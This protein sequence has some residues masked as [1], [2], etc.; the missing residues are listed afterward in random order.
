MSKVTSSVPPGFNMQKTIEQ[1]EERRRERVRFQNAAQDALVAQQKAAQAPRLRAKARAEQAAAGTVEALGYAELPDMPVFNQVTTARASMAKSVAATFAAM[2]RV[3]DNDELDG[4]KGIAQVA[5]IGRETLAQHSQTIDGLRTAL[6]R[7]QREVE[8][9]VQRAMTPPPHLARMVEQARDALRVLPAGE[10][11]ELIS[12]AKGEESIIL[13]YA[14]GAAP[15][16]LTGV[17]KGD[18]MQ[19]R[20]VLLALRD[21]PLLQ[22]EPGLGAAR[23]AV[24]KMEE[25]LHRLINSVANFEGAQALSDLRNS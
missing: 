16:F 10:R 8:E 1:A 12:K 14:I 2:G 25:G 17:Q 19:K 11:D 21:P 23:E 15:A 18:Q 20:G 3:F 22:L 13:L 24:D 9:R 4:P 6:A 7:E 5:T